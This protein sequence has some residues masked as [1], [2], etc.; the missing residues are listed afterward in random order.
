MGLG[1]VDERG[2]PMD[3]N[4]WG[5]PGSG[6][7]PQQRRG[8]PPDDHFGLDL[9]GP[10]GPMGMGPPPQQRGG[11]SGFPNHAGFGGGNSMMN[12]GANP[13]INP[14]ILKIL[15]QQQPNQQLYGGGSGNSGG[16]SGS[17]R[18]DVSVPVGL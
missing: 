6:P 18:G 15:S 5:A 13:N 4:M 17:G 2:P 11:G 12:N 10:G 3:Q 8:P 7:M 9:G 1:D 16:G 14:N